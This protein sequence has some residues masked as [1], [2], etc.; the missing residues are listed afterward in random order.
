[1]GEDWERLLDDAVDKKGSRA[2]AVRLS[3]F[4]AE[5]D[6]PVPE[7]RQ[8]EP[9]EEDAG[10]IEKEIEELRR[11]LK[12]LSEEN[13]RLKEAGAAQAPAPAENDEVTRLR[14][15]LADARAVI[16]S[17]EQ[18]YKIGRRRSRK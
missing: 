5:G 14:K 10:R 13:R 1:M 3:E 9:A 15:E 12:E 11:R 7:P 16:K 2:K 4:K 8:D 18:A 17:I 6:A